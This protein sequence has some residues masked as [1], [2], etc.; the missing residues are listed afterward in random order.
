MAAVGRKAA[1]RWRFTNTCIWIIVTSFLCIA[2]SNMYVY[3]YTRSH[4]AA[5]V[6]A[7]MLPKAFQRVLIGSGGGCASNAALCADASL[8]SQKSTC[9]K[10]VCVDIRSNAEN[11]GRCGLRCAAQLMCCGGNCVDPLSDNVHCGECNRS[12]P[13]AD[14]HL[15]LCGYAG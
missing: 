12:C 11:C 13:S 1:G 15:G 10:G 8:Y 5:A 4:V 6:R 3:D 9:C 14:C 2:I 7:E